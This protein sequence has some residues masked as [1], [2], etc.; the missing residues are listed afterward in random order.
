MV[1]SGSIDPPSGG[2]RLSVV[3]KRAVGLA[4]LLCV[5][6]T[7]TARAQCE[8][9]KLTRADA[10]PEDEFGD[11]LDLH[12]D[13]A[14]IGAWQDDDLGPESGSAYVYAN[15]PGTGWFRQAKLQPSIVS[16]G[17]RFGYS[18]STNGTVAVVGAPYDRLHGD[19]AGAAFV[20]RRDDNG[21]PTFPF[22]DLW[23]EEA[24]LESDDLSAGDKF[25]TGVAVADDF[26]AVG[27]REVN[28]LLGAAYVFRYT[29]GTWQQT[30]KL[31]P[32]PD[33]YHFG[34]SVALSGSVLVVGAY[35]NVPRSVRL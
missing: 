15:A 34:E 13:H 23:V 32:D 33:N 20:F 24:R 14:L 29:G 4:V 30:T 28:H 18:V 1:V 25:G 7:G 6:V 5:G 35:Q 8:L 16:E 3:T 21:T 2:R 26:V 31:E 17:A 27:A 10:S 12:Q 19:A 11:S 22:D 9:S